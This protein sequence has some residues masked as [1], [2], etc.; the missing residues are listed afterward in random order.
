MWLPSGGEERTIEKLSGRS[1]LPSSN[2]SLLD[3]QKHPPGYTRVKEE[4]RHPIPMNLF[5]KPWV[6]GPEFYTIT[7]FGVVQYV[8]TP[9]STTLRVGNAYIHWHW[10]WYWHIGYFFERIEGVWGGGPD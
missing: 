5:L 9:T 6:P 3:G 2:S 7:K 4:L 1:R 8:S 10:Y